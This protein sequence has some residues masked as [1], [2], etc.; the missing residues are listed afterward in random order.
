MEYFRIHLG[1]INQI[2]LGSGRR[3]MIGIHELLVFR[4]H[5]DRLFAFENFCQHHG[6]PL[7]EGPVEEC[8]L[9]CPLYGHTFNFISGHWSSEGDTRCSNNFKVWEENGNI[10]ILY[11]FPALQE[12]HHNHLHE[13]LV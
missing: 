3:F 7:V 4:T 8:K 10:I 6:K 12:T 2:P 9:E 11:Y 5:E 1:N 13:K